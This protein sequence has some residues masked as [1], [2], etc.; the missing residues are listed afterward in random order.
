MASSKCRR[1]GGKGYYLVDEDTAIICSCV[2]KAKDKLKIKRVIKESN[3][4][5]SVEEYKF[6]SYIGEDRTGNLKKIE[7]YIKKFKEKF[8]DKSL[9]FFGVGSVQKTTLMS[10]IGRELSFLGYSVHFTLMDALIKLI[11]AAQFDEDKAIEL[12]RI[13]KCDLI[14]LDDCFDKKKVTL[15]KSEYQLSFLDSFLRNRLEI[16]KGA[17]IFTSNIEIGDIN[18]QGFGQSIQDLVERNAIPLEFSDRVEL[19]DKFD[20]DTLWD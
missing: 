9:Y 5:K 20:I 19:K 17:T 10:Y 13:E 12:I 16:R 14:L 8:S 4:P 2:K 7:I 6:D 18:N 11:T 15:Y 1:C 3:L